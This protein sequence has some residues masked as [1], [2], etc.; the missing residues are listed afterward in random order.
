VP[1]IPALGRQRQADLCEFKASL[2]Y[3]LNPEQPE[4][5]HRETLSQ[6]IKNKKQ[7]PQNRV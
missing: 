5:L 1:L 4:L 6:N 3:K 7:K 2:V